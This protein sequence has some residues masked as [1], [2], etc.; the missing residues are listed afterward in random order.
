MTRLAVYAG[1]VASLLVGA[2]FA[3]KWNNDRVRS[4]LMAQIHADAAESADKQKQKDRDIETE[5]DNLDDAGLLDVWL[6][7]ALSGGRPN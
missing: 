1:L 2:G 5:I 3:L 6:S 7:Q 4:D